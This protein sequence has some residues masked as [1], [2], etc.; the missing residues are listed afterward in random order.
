MSQYYLTVAQQKTIG[1][2]P[3]R[4]VNELGIEIPVDNVIQSAGGSPMAE[5][6]QLGPLR[7][8]NRSCIHPLEG[9][10]TNRDSSPSTHTLCRCKNF[11]RSGTKFILGTRPWR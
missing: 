1:V 3:D 2:F 5:P 4:V 6:L 11:G 8:G 10:N 9:W 7:A